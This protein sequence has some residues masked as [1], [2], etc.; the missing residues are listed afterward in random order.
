[1]V[2]HYV[3]PTEV[4]GALLVFPGFLDFARNDADESPHFP[5]K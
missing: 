2:P 4:E 3:T 5:S 1:M